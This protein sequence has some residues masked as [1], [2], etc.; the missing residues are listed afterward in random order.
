MVSLPWVG[1]LIWI[2]PRVDRVNSNKVDSETQMGKGRPRGEWSKEHWKEKGKK[3]TRVQ[4]SIIHVHPRMR[5]SLHPIKV[6]TG[7]AIFR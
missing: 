2:R 6:G 4:A 7:F 5:S 1:E 3:L